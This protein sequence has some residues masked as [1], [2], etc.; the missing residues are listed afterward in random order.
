MLVYRE[1]GFPTICIP[2]EGC[3]DFYWVGFWDQISYRHTSYLPLSL[4]SLPFPKSL[5][6]ASVLAS[7]GEEG[8]GGGVGGGQQVEHKHT[9]LPHPLCLPSWGCWAEGPIS[10][11]SEPCNQHCQTQLPV[12]LTGW[13]SK[14]CMGILGRLASCWLLLE[15]SM[16]HVKPQPVSPGIP[17]CWT[18]LALSGSWVWI[19]LQPSHETPP[20]I[21]DSKEGAQNVL[22]AFKLRFFFST[23]CGPMLGF[24]SLHFCTAVSSSR[25]GHASTGFQKFELQVFFY[26]FWPN[27][28]LFCFV[29]LFIFFKNNVCPH[30]GS[31]T[32]GRNRHYWYM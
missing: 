4:S 31:W 10:S 23:Y 30:Q 13:H 29:Y 25:L 19:D 9:C 12:G 7:V 8:G 16:E 27:C 15:G 6:Q 1:E 28:W 3:I 14:Q 24:N 22:S 17:L 18:D 26:R 5:S 21:S 11:P 20:H 32:C 2:Q